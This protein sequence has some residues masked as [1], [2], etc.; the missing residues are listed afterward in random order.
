MLKTLKLF[1]LFLVGLAFL[2]NTTSVNAETE[3]TSSDTPSYMYTDQIVVGLIHSFSCIVA[4]TS[5]TTSPCTINN[6]FKFA[7][8][9]YTSELLPNSNNGGMVGS[10]QNI[11]TLVITNPPIRTGSYLAGITDELVFV[12]KADAQVVGSG[13]GILDP[14]RRLWEV[15][16]NFAYV[17]MTLIFVVV[18]FMIMFRQKINPQTVIS[19]QAALPGLVIGLVLITFSYF[20]A[21]L[22]TDTAYLATNLVGFYF[23]AAQDPPIQP[24]NQPPLPDPR[25][26]YSLV[27]ATNQ[28]NVITIMSRF[29]DGFSVGDFQDAARIFFINLTPETQNFVRIAAGLL[30]YQYGSMIG[31]AVGAAGGAGI[32]AAGVA[33][34]V[35]SP[36]C[37]AIGSAIGPI[38]TGGIASAIT[39][40]APPETIGWALWFVVVAIIIY[41]MFRL[42]LRLINN[43]LNI[44]FLTITAPFQFL[45]ASLPGRQGIV[46]DWIRNMLCNVLAFPAVIGVF[47]FIAYLLKQG[48]LEGQ[49]FIVNTTLTLTQNQTL[50]IFGGLNID[51]IRIL[52]ALGALM[53]TPAIP[54]IVCGAIGKLGK[55][56]QAI[57]QEISGAQRGGQQ[58]LSK[59]TSPFSQISGQVT[60]AQ[61]AWMKRSP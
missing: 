45:A 44:I 36:I 22:I 13:Q 48:P 31:P 40:A 42:I 6:N 50:P 3:A 61:Q 15:S 16:R 21:S 24:P 52:L 26:D 19:L 55:A 46:T 37:L 32:C 4:G 57:S 53:A 49:P 25:I 20:I 17:T 18:G 56:G 35:L 59:A 12:K 23:S 39:A 8:N 28:E 54:D 33:S 1:I 30:A 29:I 47:Y 51:F 43:Y 11:L 34:L 10:L 41:T 2:L 9:N 60:A 7:E 27:K 38:L 58:Y 14:I 5:P